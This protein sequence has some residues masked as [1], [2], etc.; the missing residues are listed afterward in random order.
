MLDTKSISSKKF[1][2]IIA[3]IFIITA[4]VGYFMMYPVFEKRAAEYDVDAFSSSNFLFQLYQGS[5]V[6]YK[7]VTE[8]ATGRTVEYA[9][10]YLQAEEEML[11]ELDGAEQEF[12]DGS[13]LNIGSYANAESW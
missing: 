9:D 2:F 4:S 10:L 3:L 6:L 11:G 13:T 7:D 12:F 8:A 1:S 5:C